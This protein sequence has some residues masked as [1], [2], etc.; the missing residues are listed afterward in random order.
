MDGFQNVI[1]EISSK[2]QRKDPDAIWYFEKGTLK[3]MERYETE[4][5]CFIVSK[6]SDKWIRSRVYEESGS[7]YL[8]EQNIWGK[9]QNTEEESLM[10]EIAKD[11]ILKKLK[12]IMEMVTFLNLKGESDALLEWSFLPNK[13]VCRSIAILLPKMLLSEGLGF[14]LKAECIDNGDGI[15][16]SW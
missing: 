8:T 2:I 3:E 10:L 1:T 11:W 12:V 14:W 6:V 7:I 9:K 16:L 5:E 15:V 4:G 13:K